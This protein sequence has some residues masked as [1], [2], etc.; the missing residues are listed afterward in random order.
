MNTR[1]QT[2]KM[3]IEM[4][5]EKEKARKFTL[6]KVEINFDEASEGWRANK[7]CIGNGHY[8]Y[9]CL[10]KTKSGNQCKRESLKFCDNCK[11]HQPKNI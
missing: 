9:I 7:K 2:K 1:S 8:K 11:I 3:N 6:Y 5:K 4:E 10:G